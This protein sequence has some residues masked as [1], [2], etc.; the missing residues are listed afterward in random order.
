[1]VEASATAG[2]SPASIP[3]LRCKLY[4]HHTLHSKLL[5]LYSFVAVMHR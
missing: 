2:N 3:H 5:E 4:M 1:M